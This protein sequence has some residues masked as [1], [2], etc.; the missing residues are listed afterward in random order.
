M[1]V[2]LGFMRAVLAV[3]M[4]RRLITCSAIEESDTTDVARESRLRFL[5]VW[6]LRVMLVLVGMIFILLALTGF[7]QVE[8]QYLPAPVACAAAMAAW[9]FIRLRRD[10]LARKVELKQAKAIKNL[11]S[12]Q[13]ESNVA[14]SASVRWWRGARS[15]VSKRGTEMRSWCAPQRM[16]VEVYPKR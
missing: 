12:T 16:R 14:G 11:P 15:G 8:P 10:E 3:L 6:V 9:S 4:A 5:L 13:N 7:L 1:A 2:L